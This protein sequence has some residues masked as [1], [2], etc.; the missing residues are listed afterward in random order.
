MTS[1]K[2]RT[3]TPTNNYYAADEYNRQEKETSRKKTS[4]RGNKIVENVRKESRNFRRTWIP[5]IKSIL[6]SATDLVGDWVFYFRTKNG[7]AGIPLDDLERPLYYLCLISTAFG[8]LAIMGLLLNNIKV[9]NKFKQNCMTRINYLLGLEILVEDVPQ[10][11]FTTLVSIRKN[12]GVWTPVAVF[13]VTTSAFNCVLNILDMLMPL[14]ET[15]FEP[16]P[17]ENL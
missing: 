10:M 16:L 7:D 5:V 9:E 14:D 1:D 11:I 15:Y 2:N 12:G 6:S 3:L 4:S 8:A 17:L 13:N